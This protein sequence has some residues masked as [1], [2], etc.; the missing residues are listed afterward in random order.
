MAKKIVKNSEVVLSTT[1]KNKPVS[2]SLVTHQV[3]DE[4]GA[5]R[6]LSFKSFVPR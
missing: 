1:V 3:E 2:V 6:C 5:T 4:Q